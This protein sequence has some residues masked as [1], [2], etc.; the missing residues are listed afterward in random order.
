MNQKWPQELTIIR[1][2]QSERNVAKDAA[3]AAGNKL[4]Y[5]DSVRDQDTALTEF[6]MA[7]A[8]A[9]GVALRP[10]GTYPRHYDVALVSP[11]LR[12]RQTAAQVYLGMGYK[13]EEVIEERIREIEFGVF[14]GLTRQGIEA[15]YPE[16][17]RRR[18]KE[19]K[20]WF[21]PWGGESRPD[22]AMRG[23]SV[24]STLTRDYVGKRVLVITHS[25]MVLIF[26]R[27]LERWGE[28]EYLR[29]DREDDVKNCSVTRYQTNRVSGKL[30]LECYN[31][32]VQPGQ[33][34]AEAEQVL[35]QASQDLSGQAEQCGAR[36]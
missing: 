32:T 18:E 6:G 21:R 4:S 24:L 19:G 14:D 11:L 26:R 10:T 8:L 7:Q 34:I 25:V 2:G 3:K 22:C 33:S 12:T 15:K 30:I 20:Y 36:A 31:L 16:E 28:E 9:L 27:L 13:P 29:V 17:I 23:H 1:H 5:V 35:L